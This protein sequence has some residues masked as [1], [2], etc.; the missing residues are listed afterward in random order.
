MEEKNWEARFQDHRP[1]L[2]GQRRWFDPLAAK[3]AFVYWA[4]VVIIFLALQRSGGDMIGIGS[5]PVL[6]VT[7]PSSLL[8]IAITSSG[9]SD[10]LAYAEGLL[11][12]PVE[13]FL[14]LPGLAGG[15]NAAL[16]FLVLTWIQRVRDRRKAP[17]ESVPD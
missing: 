6:L 3:V 14:M 11:S 2:P 5:Y 9:P 17:H 7:A 4:F 1:R 16:I 10:P 13:T 8:I 12:P 15:L